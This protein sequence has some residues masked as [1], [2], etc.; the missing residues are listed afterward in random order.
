[1]DESPGAAAAVAVAEPPKLRKVTKPL[2][3]RESPTPRGS[4]AS[5]VSPTSREQSPAPPGERAEPGPSFETGRTANTEAVRV[6]NT[7]AGCVAAS[8][9]GRPAP[10]TGSGHHRTFLVSATGRPGSGVRAPA[11]P[12]DAASTAA[13]SAV[14][15]AAAPDEP[16]VDPAPPGPALAGEAAGEMLA[17]ALKLR[18]ARTT[19]TD[20]RAVR[21]LVNAAFAEYRGT[22]VNFT[23]IDQDETETL[24]RMEGRQVWLAFDGRRAAA[25]ISLEFKTDSVTPDPDA[26]DGAAGMAP[27][28]RV[29]FISQ[30]A[31]SP[32]YKGRGLGTRL[33]MFAEGVSA[34]EGAVEVRLSTADSI[35]HLLRFYDRRGYRPISRTRWPG[36][37][38]DSVILGKALTPR[39]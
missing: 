3:S 35:E 15:P 19:P 38:Y 16:L 25:T 13:P 21:R 11:V 29:A 18:L 34:E 9:A 28:R 24:A 14:A 37:T 2:T 27:V 32:L 23:G 30:F 20:V 6:A 5:P 8:E 7:D 1:M 12:A 31:V 33:L 22:S 26:P 17:G 10:G 39:A 4:K 36:K